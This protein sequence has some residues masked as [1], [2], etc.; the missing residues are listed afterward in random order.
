MTPVTWSASIHSSRCTCFNEA[1][2]SRRRGHE[3][4]DGRTGAALAS[5]EPAPHD[6]GDPEECRCRRC[7]GVGRTRRGENVSADNWTTCPACVEEVTAAALV[8]QQRVADACPLREAIQMPREKG[9]ASNSSTAR[10]P[11]LVGT[12]FPSPAVRNPNATRDLSA[13]C[14]ERPSGDASMRKPWSALMLCWAPN[15]VTWP[16]ATARRRIAAWLRSLSGVAGPP[17]IKMHSIYASRAGGA[18]AGRGLSS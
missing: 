15:I 4:R 7:R 8:G 6:A 14:T 16:S 5:T 11:V 18:P 10:R 13:C 3:H 1:G 9:Y 12:H 17:P 2:V